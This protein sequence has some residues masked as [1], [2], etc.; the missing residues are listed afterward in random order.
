MGYV[1]Y[2]LLWPPTNVCR[3]RLQMTSRTPT[4]LPRG[5]DD[6]GVRELP[7][8]RPLHEP[9]LNVA[10][11]P[12]VQLRPGWRGTLQGEQPGI[13]RVVLRSTAQAGHAQHLQAV[14]PADR[15]LVL[16]ADERVPAALAG[17]RQDAHPLPGRVIG[18]VPDATVRSP[19]VSPVK[20][21]RHANRLAEYEHAFDAPSV[22]NRSRSAHGTHQC[23]P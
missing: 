2:G 23:P 16:A 3:P 1:R 12:I 11:G 7:A 17:G 21:R 15:R 6:R 5:V 14:G 20:R 18:A 13:I 22:A 10:V 8:H 19:R 9:R 4:L